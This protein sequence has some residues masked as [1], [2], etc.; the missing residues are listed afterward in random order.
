MSH[1]ELPPKSSIRLLSFVTVLIIRYKWHVDGRHTVVKDAVKH[2]RRP[3]TL[4]NSQI[5]LHAKNEMY[6]RIT[7]SPTARKE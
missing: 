5:S 7:A 1:E 2:F 3:E 6:P 4:F